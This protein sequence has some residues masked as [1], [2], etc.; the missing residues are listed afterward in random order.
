MI[1]FCYR[2]EHVHELSL[3]TGGC[4]TAVG[5]PL[6]PG[7]VTSYGI[8]PSNC[9]CQYP[10]VKAKCGSGHASSCPVEVEYQADK[11]RGWPRL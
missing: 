7:T 11:K 4:Q 1:G 10:M 5:A 2:C 9:T 3:L 6:L 8:K